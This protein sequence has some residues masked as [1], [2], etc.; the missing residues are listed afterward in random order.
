M[1][2][3]GMY[4]IAFLYVEYKLTFVAHYSFLLIDF[5]KLVLWAEEFSLQAEIHI[6]M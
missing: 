2:K 3:K 5:D 6:Y 1:E 4:N